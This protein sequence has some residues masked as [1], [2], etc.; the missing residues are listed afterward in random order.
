MQRC[1]S[2][3]NSSSAHLCLVLTKMHNK[4]FTYL[5]WWA[6]MHTNSSNDNNSISQHGPSTRLVETRARQHDPCWRA[7]ETGHPSTRPINSA[8]GNS[9]PPVNTAHVDGQWKPVTHQLGPSTRVV[10]T[11]LNRHRCWWPTT[12]ET[13]AWYDLILCTLMYHKPKADG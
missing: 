7:M 6:G 10:E 11:G 5:P 1:T 4:T 12:T 8:S 9:R 2:T 3:M 13:S